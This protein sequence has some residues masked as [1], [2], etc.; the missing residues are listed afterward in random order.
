MLRWAV[1][2]VV[3][4]HG[5]HLFHA[6]GAFFGFDIFAAICALNERV[7]FCGL[8]KFVDRGASAR[9]WTENLGGVTPRHEVRGVLVRAA[10]DQWTR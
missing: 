2:R 7:I 5:V 4:K 8:G 1:G 10:H 3:V 9:L 6:C